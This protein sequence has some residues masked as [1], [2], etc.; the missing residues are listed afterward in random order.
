[1][2]VMFAPCLMTT[3]C[4]GAAQAMQGMPCRVCVLLKLLASAS[5]CTCAW[6][7]SDTAFFLHTSAC[8]TRPTAACHAGQLSA[9][10]L[11]APWCARYAPSISTLHFVKRLS[12]LN[13]CIHGLRAERFRMLT[14][15]L[16]AAG[17]VLCGSELGP[18]PFVAPRV[19]VGCVDA[20]LWVIRCNGLP[21]FRAESFGFLQW[22]G[23]GSS[24]CMRSCCMHAYGWRS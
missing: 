12:P 22:A 3:S 2:R 8:C 9:S 7:D 16:W 4:L 6:P 13:L 23:S 20:A 19:C 21:A 17:C 18:Y 1:M 11:T 14:G 5:T 24:Q 10:S 15:P